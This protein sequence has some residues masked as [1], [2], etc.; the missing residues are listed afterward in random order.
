MPGV[1]C[2][3]KNEYFGVTECKKAVTLLSWLIN[4]RL[5]H[6]DLGA[7]EPEPM[8]QFALEH[9]TPVGL[10]VFELLVSCEHLRTCVV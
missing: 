3:L 7:S 4:T 2:T 10:C 6:T 1:H 8:I 9:S 5:S